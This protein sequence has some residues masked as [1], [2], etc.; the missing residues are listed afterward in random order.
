MVNNR[1][2]GFD[3]ARA[4]AIFGMFIVNFNIVF[5]SH[6][7]ESVIGQFLNLFN[8]N[9]S[10]M[11]V[12]LAGMGVALMTNRAE[13]SVA[14]RQKLKAIVM[15]RGT[16]LFVFGLLFYN[17]WF[18]DILH[19]YGSYLHIAALLL[20]V[21]KRFY[22]WAA[23][24]SILIFHLL[25]FVIPY[26]TGWNFETLQYAGFWTLAGFLR[27]TFY[28]GWN[29]VFPWIGFFLLGMWL[30][31]LDWQNTRIKRNILLTGIGVFS[32]VE[33]LQ[34]FANRGY[35]NEDFAFYLTADYIP[36]FLPFMLGTAGFSLIL[37]TVCIFIGEKFAESKWLEYFSKTGQMTL[38]HYVAHLTFGM[39]ILSVMSGKTDF[40]SINGN[41]SISPMFILNYAILYYILSVIFSVMWSKRFKNGPLETLMRKFSG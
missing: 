20:F 8:G 7:D 32:L 3:L 31:R 12:M 40:N 21:P 35:F 39:I 22:L 41:D 11:F 26:E 15:K 27:N 30:G 23:G 24:A 2:L 1:I 4:Y 34:M 10:S 19:F 36:P 6:N 18:A 5:G 28:N 9:S 25:L 17:W 13:Y 16:F 33:I 14:E 29:P 38:T 37:I